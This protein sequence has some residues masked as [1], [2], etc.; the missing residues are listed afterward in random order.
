M[1][2]TQYIRDSVTHELG[3]TW[4]LG[5]AAFSPDDDWALIFT[6]KRRATAP[7]ASALIQ[8]ASGA[9]ITV[10]GSTASVAI[11]PADTTGLTATETFLCDV[12]AQHVLTGEVRTVWVG[13]LQCILDITRETTTSIPVHTTEPPLPFFNIAQSTHAAASKTT[14]VDADEIPLADSAASWA[15]KKLTWANLKATLK[16]YLD[17]FYQAVLVSG[18]NLKTINGTSLLGAGDL[19]VGGDVTSATTSDGT[20]ALYLDSIRFETTNGG[21]T[22]TGQ[23]AWESTDGSIDAMLE[24][25]VIVA[26]GEDLV[27]RVRN[28][29]ASPIAKGAALAYDGTVGASGRIDV[30]PWV[31]S[32]IATAKLFLGFAAAAIDANGN[33]Y[34][35]WFGKLSGINT[36]GGAQ[37]W[38]DEQLIYA[39]PGTSSTI[40]NVAPTSG[41]YGAVAVVVNAGSGT[42]GILFIRPTFERATYPPTPHTHVTADITDATSD[43]QTN[44]GKLLKTDANGALQI[45]TLSLGSSDIDATD[46][47]ELIIYN[48]TD[49]ESV[50]GS[51]KSSNLTTARD[52]ELPNTSGTIMLGDGESILKIISLTQAEYD[53]ITPSSTTLYVIV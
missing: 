8:K 5:G 41:E 18:T 48:A 45:N 14:P 26:M 17:A 22:Q 3:L 11:V 19:S 23:M 13:R 39:V 35:Q 49:V 15:L 1:T 16:S 25:G 42:S 50:Y 9:G 27:I 51:I 20:A 38:Q 30:K 47:G 52:F 44:P 37:N 46:P 43:G 2:L 53:A 24:S 40:T 6:A 34:S 10:G 32:N 33:G 31:G 7:D 21:P 29:T 36:S 4:P 28:A 12:Q